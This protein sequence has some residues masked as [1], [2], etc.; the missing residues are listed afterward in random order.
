MVKPPHHL[1][2]DFILWGEQLRTRLLQDVKFECHLGPPFDKQAAFIDLQDAT[3]IARI[4]LWD[5]GEHEYERSLIDDETGRIYHY[6]EQIESSQF[7]QLFSP[8]TKYYT[9]F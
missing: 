9:A 3:T 8:I 2:S 7:E 6:G 4:M 1:L 5:S